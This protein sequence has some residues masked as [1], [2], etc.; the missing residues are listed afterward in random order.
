MP[1]PFQGGQALYSHNFDG[2]EPM[3]Q[4]VVDMLAFLGEDRWGSLVSVRIQ[5]VGLEG[6]GK[7]N[8]NSKVKGK[9]SS[10]QSPEATDA[11]A[12]TAPTAPKSKTE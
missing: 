11:E 6:G 8:G 7:G 3:P 4:W 1:S 12:P 10:A 5:I 9:A 2:D